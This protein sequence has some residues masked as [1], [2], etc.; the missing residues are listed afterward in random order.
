[1][2]IKIQ[3]YDYVIE[4]SALTTMMTTWSVFVRLLFTVLGANIDLV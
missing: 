4:D 2:N 3:Q 1:M